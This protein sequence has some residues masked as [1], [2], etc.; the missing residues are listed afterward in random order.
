VRY[1]EEVGRVEGLLRELELEGLPDP[2]L[3]LTRFPSE[4][5]V[6]PIP[7]LGLVH[8]VARLRGVREAWVATEKGDSRQR[9]PLHD[10]VS[11]SQ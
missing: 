11:K 2:R 8:D 4:L 7:L 6:I 5:E 3:K 1:D 9:E 10:H